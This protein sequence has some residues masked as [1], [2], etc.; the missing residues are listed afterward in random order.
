MANQV[1]Y[2]KTSTGKYVRVNDPWAYTGLTTGHWHVHVQAHS[3]TM[4]QM[5]QPDY[6]PIEAA[7][8]EIG[9]ELVE[10]IS[11]ASRP[12][13]R[14]PLTP[15]QSKAWKK[16]CELAGAGTLTC[17]SVSKVAEKIMEV[18]R[19]KVWRGL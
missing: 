18:V 7:F 19:K 17:E 3:V 6:A 16:L 4:R 15:E 12:I 10:I 1:F 14:R 5:I 9:G 11:E 13:A 2:R 8:N